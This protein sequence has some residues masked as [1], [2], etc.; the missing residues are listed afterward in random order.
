MENTKSIPLMEAFYTIQGEGFHS[1][2]AAYFIRT[3]GCDVGCVWCDVKDSWD[4]DAHPEVEIQTI[5]EQVKASKT[6][7]VVI[8]GGEPTMYDLTALTKALKDAGMEIAIETSGA[9]PITGQIDWICL[10]PKKFKMPLAE[11]YQKAHELKMIIFNR[12]DFKWSEEL[13]DKVSD[14]CKLFLQTE[15]DQSEKM[16]PL[17]IDYVKDNSEWNISLQTHKYLNIP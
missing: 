16:L 10:S 17:I 6:D 13:K 7:F 5:V 8:T 11:N 1:G 4:K 12:H 15:W 3:A 9:Y 2:R 14:D